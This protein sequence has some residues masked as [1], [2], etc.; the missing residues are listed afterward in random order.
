MGCMWS[1]QIEVIGDK[2]SSGRKI[3]SYRIQMLPASQLQ[4]TDANP[5]WIAVTSRDT[6][7]KDVGK[8]GSSSTW[9][10]W[11]TQRINQ[12]FQELEKR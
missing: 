1:S 12:A 2:S 5:S 3:H 11:S 7:R 6:I 10:I 4:H 9:F 8:S